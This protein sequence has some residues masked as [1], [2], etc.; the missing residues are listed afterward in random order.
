MR[1]I[2]AARGIIACAAMVAAFV[3][4]LHGAA[5]PQEHHSNPWLKTWIPVT[6]C[7]TNDCC[8]EVAERE[9]K[10]LPDDNYEVRST[11]QVRKRTDWS[12]DG[13]HYR[14]ACDFDAAEKQWIRHQGA[15][16]RC[17]FIPMRTM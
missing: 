3:L 11:G 10:P 5:L 1:L 15:N 4:A 2:L 7:V 12:P 16:T 9:L 14:C 13:K 6:C 8:W 17:I